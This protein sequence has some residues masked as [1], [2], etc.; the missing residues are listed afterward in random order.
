METEQRLLHSI[1]RESYLILT[2]F[3]V[4]GKYI[5]FANLCFFIYKSKY[6]IYKYMYGCALKEKTYY[7]Q[8]YIVHNKGRHKMYFHR[9]LFLLFISKYN[10]QGRNWVI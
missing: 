6:T 4:G 1:I 10:K 3:C 9:R 8:L 7:V 2:I 5:C